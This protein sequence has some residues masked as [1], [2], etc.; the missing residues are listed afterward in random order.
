LSNP[1][2]K[3]DYHAKLTLTGNVITSQDNYAT[4]LLPNGDELHVKILKVVLRKTRHAKKRTALRF[5]RQKQ[6]STMYTKHHKTTNTFTV[7]GDLNDTRGDKLRIQ[8][9]STASNNEDVPFEVTLH[10]ETTKE[11]REHDDITLNGKNASKP[12]RL[13]QTRN[14]TA[15]K[16]DSPTGTVTR[17]TPKRGR[18]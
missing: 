5:Q 1:K 18:S 3:G 14:K 12:A 15:P 16:S 10:S 8:V 11:K 4:I 7:T 13:K 17:S 9:K 6:R 2:V